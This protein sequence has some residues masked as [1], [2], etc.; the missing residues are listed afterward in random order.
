MNMSYCRF[1]NT[2]HQ[3]CDC[4]ENM[5]TKD[6]SESEKKYRQRLIELCRGIAEQYDIEED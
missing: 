1:E 3:L 2:Y 5:N 4:D 6:L